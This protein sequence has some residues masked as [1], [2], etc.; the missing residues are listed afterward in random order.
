MKRYC[1]VPKRL[2]CETDL[3]TNMA[4]FNILYNHLK[5]VDLILKHTSRH[6]NNIHKT[7]STLI[8]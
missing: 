2:I 6:I 3:L 5:F 8:I 7:I 4:C 1:L